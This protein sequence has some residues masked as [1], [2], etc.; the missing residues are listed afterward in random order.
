MTHK[1]DITVTTP[2]IKDALSW[3][4][5]RLKHQIYWCFAQIIG[6]RWEI[7]WC[8]VV[9]D[10]ET[11]KFVGT[12]NYDSLDALEISGTKW[13]AFG[14][15][16]YRNI[17]FPEYDLCDQPLELNKF[18][19][20]IAEQVL[21]H[22]L[23]PFRAVSNLYKMLRPGGILV[24]TTPF[25]LRIHDEPADCSRWTEVGL[26]YLLAA[27]GF[28]LSNITTGSWGNRACVKANFDYWRRWIPWKHSLTNE[29]EFP[30]VVWAFCTKQKETL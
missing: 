11:E 28:D 21:E 3:R 6:V 27:G 24:V 26:K 4:M 22:V 2:Q 13:K 9:M 10:R 18:D 16:S 20:I 19:I 23:W 14:F 12:L 17:S 5:R 29:P 30:V 25:L 15:A 7:Q 1:T 8:R